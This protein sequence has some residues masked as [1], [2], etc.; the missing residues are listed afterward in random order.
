MG[1][2][3]KKNI[4]KILI[5]YFNTQLKTLAKKLFSI[6]MKIGKYLFSK[7]FNFRYLNISEFD[8]LII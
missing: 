7:I 5:Q 4:H 2:L 8:N 1:L 3:S 6:G